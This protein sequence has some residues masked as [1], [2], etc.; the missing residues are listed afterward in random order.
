MSGLREDGLKEWP[1]QRKWPGV[2]EEATVRSGTGHGSSHSGRGW[3]GGHGWAGRGGGGQDPRPG[4]TG[5]AA[6]C[7]ALPSLRPPSPGPAAWLP[8]PEG[9]SWRLQPPLGPTCGRPPA[10]PPGPRSATGHSWQAGVFTS[11]RG[12]RLGCPL[13]CSQSRDVALHL[14]DDTRAP[15]TRSSAL[16]VQGSRGPA[17]WRP[18]SHLPFTMPHPL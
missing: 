16:W 18:P 10:A 11:A 4:P 5:P 14:T 17:T 12:R 6:A 3:E 8:A 9:L 15:A 13:C 1:E 7:S 2:Q